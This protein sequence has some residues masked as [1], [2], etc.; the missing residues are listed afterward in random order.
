MGKSE[1]LNLLRN[2]AERLSYSE[3]E[4]KKL[5]SKARKLGDTIKSYI[6]EKFNVDCEYFIAGSLAKKT[7]IK[8]HSDIDIFLRFNPN[9]SKDYLKNVIITVGNEIFGKE[10]VVVRYAEH[11]Y[12]E[13]NLKDIKLSVVPSYKVKMGEW[14]SAVDRTYYH[15]IYVKD[16]LRENKWLTKEIILLKAFMKRI[17]V[18]GAEIYVKGFSG[19]LC[20]LLTI[21]YNGFL[22]LIENV[23]NNWRPPIIIDLEKHY[24]NP[25]DLI[26]IFKTPLIVIDPIDPSRNVAAIVSAKSLMKF[27]SAAKAFL[28]YPREEFFN[29]KTTR[30]RQLKLPNE[31]QI[32][33]LKVKHNY[34]IPDILYSQLEK[35]MNK[36]TRQ[37]I[38]NGFQIYRREIYTNY[39]DLSIIIFLLPTLKLPKINIRAGPYP[40]F[41]EESNFIK[42]NINKYIWIDED[43]R[44]KV[45]DYRKWCNAEDVVKYTLKTIKIPKYLVNS[46]ITILTNEEL[47]KDNE[48]KPLIENLNLNTDFWINY[49]TTSQLK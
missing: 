31:V 43:G 39:Q 26:K 23:A 29:L 18:Y 8:G 5:D 42:K 11:P 49:Y 13:V 47:T 45:L 48:I 38:S 37:L 44:W 12:I 22:N 7:M 24:K 36:V 35:L 41:K 6:A 20:E 15:V 27:I 30:Y 25:K 19:Y 28:K 21:Y 14:R 46:K 3:E 32:L 1:V 4:Y 9:L 16:K 10:N 2:I 17:G 33:C 40:Y 34:L